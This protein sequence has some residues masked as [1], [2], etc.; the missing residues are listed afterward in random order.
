MAITTIEK[1]K[2]E[3]HFTATPPDGCGFVVGDRVMLTNDYGISF[4]PYRVFGFDKSPAAGRVVF[5]ECD[6]YWLPKKISQL[7]KIS[8]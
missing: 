3:D 1:I 2:T 5:V 4:G 8:D 6:S 7:H